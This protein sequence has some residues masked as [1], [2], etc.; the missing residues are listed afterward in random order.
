MELNH[1][2][3]ETHLKEARTFIRLKM[4]R[5]LLMFHGSH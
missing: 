2:G 4:G 3:S 5:I 1:Y